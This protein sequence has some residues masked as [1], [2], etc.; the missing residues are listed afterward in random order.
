M[1]LTS[2]L[3][4]LLLIGTAFGHDHG[5]PPS[6]TTPHEHLRPHEHAELYLN[7]VEHLYFAIIP[8]MDSISDAAAATPQQC[9]EIMALYS[10]LNMAIDHM[11]HNPDMRQEVLKILNN[12]PQRRQRLEKR[13]QVYI[14]S[15]TRCKNTG[16]IPD[17]PNIRRIT[18][19]T[20]P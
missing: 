8:R 6:D 20:E 13:Q 18:I 10:R 19:P 3:L 11:E 15:A 2:G 9:Q 17:M 5:L 16:L 4:S 1:K 12:N 7:L 14:Q